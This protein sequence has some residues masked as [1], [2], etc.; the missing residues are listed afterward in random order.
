MTERETI[1]LP[2]SQVATNERQA[3]RRTR[4]QTRGRHQCGGARALHGQGCRPS[5]AQRAARV[6]ILDTDL[7]KICGHEVI[8]PPTQH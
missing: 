3:R 2:S 8:V 1:T 7:K 5:E 4:T 6:L